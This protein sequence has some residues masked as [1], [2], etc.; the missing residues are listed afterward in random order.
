MA[1]THLSVCLYVRFDLKYFKEIIKQYKQ[2]GKLEV[3][4]I[5]LLNIK[6]ES[7]WKCSDF[8]Y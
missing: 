8:F 5:D 6:V 3:V 2:T 7:K 4:A 1:E